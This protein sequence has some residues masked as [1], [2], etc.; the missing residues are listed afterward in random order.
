MY[1]REEISRALNA[2]RE[3]LDADVID[4]DINAV[5]NK[6]K[7]LTQLTGLSAETVASAEKILHLKELE[8]F[9]ENLPKGYSASNLNG[10]IKAET[11]EEIALLVY[12]DRINAAL[13]RSMDA[14]RTSISLYKTE[15]TAGTIPGQTN[16]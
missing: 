8:S 3:T 1:T 4:C 14:L 11:A 15:L 10:L 16:M 7:K 2:I 13:S 6:L 9:R 12:A 5:D